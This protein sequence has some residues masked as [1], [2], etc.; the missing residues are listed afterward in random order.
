MFPGD[1]NNPSGFLRVYFRKRIAVATNIN[2]NISNF[3]ASFELFENY[4]NPFNSSTKIRWQS[5]VS[6]HQVI[7]IYDLTGNE[8]TTLVNEYKSAGVHEIQ[9]NASRLRSGIYFYTL[10]AENFIQVKKMVLIK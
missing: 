2:E 4:P 8:I 10:E 3:P 6:G 9:F 5:S 1:I 7:K